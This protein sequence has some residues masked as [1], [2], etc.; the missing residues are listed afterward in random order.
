[1]NNTTTTKK[2]GAPIR[3]SP[4]FQVISPVIARDIFLS[5]AYKMTREIKVKETKDKK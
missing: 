5:V 4:R 1:M 2:D 3:K